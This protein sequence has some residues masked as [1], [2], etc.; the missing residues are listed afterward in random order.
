MEL[1]YR[2]THFVDV[3]FCKKVQYLHCISW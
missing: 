2:K 1:Q 3:D